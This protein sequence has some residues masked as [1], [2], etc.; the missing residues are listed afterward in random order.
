MVIDPLT[1]DPLLSLD[2]DPDVLPTDEEVD[3]YQTHGWYITRPVIS[4]EMI[5]LALKG[6]ERLYNGDLDYSL[7]IQT[8]FK[9]WSPEDGD[10][11]RNNEFT[12]LQVNELRRFAQQPVI[13]AIAAR[14]AKT[15]SIRLFDDQVVYKPPV[16]DAG[17]GAVGW[18]TD[19]AY[20]SNCTSPQLLTGWIPF[21]DCDDAIGP[22]VVIDQSHRWTGTDHFRF[23]NSQNLDELEQNLNQF[24]ATIKK[25]PMTLKKGQ[26]SF[27]H[28]SA[29]HGSYPNRSSQPRRAMALHLQ[30]ASN[31][32]QPC[33][34]PDGTPIHHVLDQVCCPLPN[35]DPDYGDPTVF[36]PLWPL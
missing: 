16:R 9:N 10:G 23:F 6:C 36:L 21:H 22:L 29:M 20:Y 27:H 4:D 13:G 33:E 1:L 24:S 34:R 12:A 32:Y 30:D 3:F 26:M 2:I 25:I 8:G 7:P 31:G 5:E 17:E 14:L 19:T 15:S 11:L 18:H 28:F 35:G